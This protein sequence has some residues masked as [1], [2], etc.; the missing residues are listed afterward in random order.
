MEIGIERLAALGFIIT[1]LSHI[2]APRAWARFFI[3]IRQQ[4]EAGGFINAYIHM[5]LGLLILAFHQ[6]WHGPG[7]LV[8]LVGCALTL[9]GLLYFMV[10][11][12]AVKSMARVTE[13]KAWQFRIAG[14]AGLLLG[15]L[16]GWIALANGGQVAAGPFS[17]G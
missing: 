7:L 11:E 17:I 13:E 12:L 9:K 16:I 3:L 6:V 8:T 1:G 15:F 2:A 10:P 5:P 4:G 14:L